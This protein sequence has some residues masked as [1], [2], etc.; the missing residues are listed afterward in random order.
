MLLKPVL[1]SSPPLCPVSGSHPVGSS[2]SLLPI[3]GG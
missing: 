2:L 3:T 1:P